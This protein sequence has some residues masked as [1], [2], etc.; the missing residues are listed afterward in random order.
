MLFLLLAI[1][2]PKLGPVFATASVLAVLVNGFGALSFQR[3]GWERFY[4]PTRDHAIFEPDA[5]APRRGRD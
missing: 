4:A 5:P 1:T 2:R 3:P